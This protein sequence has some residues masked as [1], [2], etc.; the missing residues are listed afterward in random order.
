MVEG[1]RT[2]VS[3]A[4]ELEYAY[5]VDHIAAL[6][7]GAGDFLAKAG[8]L[9]DLLAPKQC[10]SQLYDDKTALL[11]SPSPDLG[12]GITIVSPIMVASAILALVSVWCAYTPRVAKGTKFN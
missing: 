1:W 5:A 3:L 2:V 7:S 10:G 6:E 12:G 8:A 4:L 9:R 11:V